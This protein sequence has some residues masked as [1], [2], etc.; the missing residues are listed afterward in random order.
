MKLADMKG[1]EALAALGGLLEPLARIISDEK[2]KA[3]FKDNSSK[4]EFGSYVL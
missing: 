3:M 4:A 2:I 1:A